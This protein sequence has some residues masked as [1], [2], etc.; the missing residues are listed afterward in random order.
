MKSRP[1]RP[2][3]NIPGVKRVNRAVSEVEGK[4]DGVAAVWR[5]ESDTLHAAQSASH[6]WLALLAL[7]VTIRLPS[8][9]SRASKQP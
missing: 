4:V 1:L 2:G 5:T 6:Q 3:I 7:I 9:T 8:C